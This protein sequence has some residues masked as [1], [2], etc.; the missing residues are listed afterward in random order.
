MEVST[1]LPS[2]MA[3]MLAPFVSSDEALIRI[4]VSEASKAIEPAARA[5]LI[6][7]LLTDEL[8]AVRVAAADALADAPVDA[9][10]SAAF[11][12]AFA[13]LIKANELSSWR[14][15]GRAN[16]GLLHMRRGELD[17]AEQ[18]YITAISIDP[19]FSASYIN[20]TDIYR[21]TMQPQK[22]QQFYELAVRNLPKDATI[23][24]SYGLHL[25]R[26]GK[27][28]EAA[29]QFELSVR[30]QPDDEQ[31]LYVWLLTLDSL[32]Q[33]DKGLQLLLQRQQSRPLSARLQQLGMDMAQKAGNR[34][35]YQRLKY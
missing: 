29:E 5:K 32:K 8:R 2:T 3:Q 17:K 21:A 34:E 35:A 14:G 16:Q 20:L 26:Q 6:A 31:N 10:L 12:R 33:W 25:I 13:E 28:K 15:E 7:P 9:A 24:Y 30:Y 1:D 27:T 19:Y 22:A 11:N 18:Q 23:R 4:A